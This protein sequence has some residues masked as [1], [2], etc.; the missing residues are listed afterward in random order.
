MDDIPIFGSTT[1][2]YNSPN[3]EGL[4]LSKIHIYTL[5]HLY[6]MVSKWQQGWTIVKPKH[7]N[8]GISLNFHLHDMGHF[9][10]G[11]DENQ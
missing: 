10:V 11:L 4:T 8:N 1:F 2:N 6:M 5:N 7:G 3:H 9:L